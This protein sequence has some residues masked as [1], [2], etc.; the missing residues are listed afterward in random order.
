MRTL[1]VLAAC[2][3]PLLAAPVPKA[4]VKKAT[5]L[6][7]T[8]QVVE[9]HSGEFRMPLTDDI[10]WAIEGE[11]LTVSSTRQAV[12]DGFV[13]N[14]TRTITRPEGGAADAFVYTITSADGSGPSVRP[15]VIE[16]DGDTFKICLADTHNGPRPPEC[17]PTSGA[18]TYT[19]KR[20]APA[21]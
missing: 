3:L 20:A 15:A 19:L 21:K 8:W 4:L 5:G 6:D 7:G 13:G 2:A 17:K 9:W 12:P 10:R 11:R 1:L 14:A 18:M 16:V